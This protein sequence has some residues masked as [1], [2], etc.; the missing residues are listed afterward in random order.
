[1]LSVGDARCCRL[2]KGMTHLCDHPSGFLSIYELLR[3]LEGTL[4]SQ[5]IR[6][7]SVTQKA[8][9]Q[10]MLAT[11]GGEPREPEQEAPALKNDDLVV[12]C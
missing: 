9:E 1:V 3:T 8:G 6:G 11:V 5:P 4:R 7:P 2:G 12:K 10:A